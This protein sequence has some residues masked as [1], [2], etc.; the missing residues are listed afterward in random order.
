MPTHVYAKR[1]RR[2]PLEHLAAGRKAA[3]CDTD[4]GTTD[5]MTAVE[6]PADP[7]EK[8]WDATM[9]SSAA[10]RVKG[11][12]SLCK[13]LQTGYCIDAVREQYVVCPS[14]CRTMYSPSF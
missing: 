6:V 12:Q 1:S 10:Q 11:V 7:W 13:L 4:E 9:D 2:N 3:Q 5:S 14:V 8:A